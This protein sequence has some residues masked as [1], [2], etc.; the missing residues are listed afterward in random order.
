MSGLQRKFWF[1]ITSADIPNLLQKIGLSGIELLDINYIS[2]ITFTC[3]VKKIDFAKLQTILE[4]G[5]NTYKIKR[6]LGVLWQFWGLKERP[7]LVSGILLTIFLAL[8]LPTRVYFVQVAGNE[9]VSTRYVL[10]M[11][12][13]CGI[14]FGANRRQVRSEKVKNALLEKIPELKWVGVNTNGCTATISVKEKSIETVKK[15]EKKIGNI[16]A[17]A[18]GVVGECTVLR[19]TPMCAVGDAVTKGQ[20]L[21]SGYADQGNI[22]KISG[23]EGEVYAQTMRSFAVITNGFR[24]KR[25]EQKEAKRLFSVIIGKK[26]INFYKDSGIS[27]TSCVKMRKEKVLTLPGGMKL[28][29]VF[30]IEEIS[31]YDLLNEELTEEK[32]SFLSNYSAHYLK[33]QMIAGEIL[34]KQSKPLDDGI[35][36]GIYVTSRC[37]EMIGK[38]TYEEIMIQ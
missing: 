19:G 20:V 10:E 36:T 17:V 16:V 31:S 32:M 29:V 13:E 8:F 21:I 37:Y 5:G 2:E 12:Q 22:I 27:H 1:E 6:K 24:Q 7:V 38:A 15:V 18:D 11:A 33:E 3:V 34:E 26:Q 14:G 23:A 35:R 28:P 25:T 30:V 4:K 9:F